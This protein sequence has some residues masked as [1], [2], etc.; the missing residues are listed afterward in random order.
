MQVIKIV[1]V[2]SLLKESHCYWHCGG[3]KIDDD[4]QCKCHSEVLTKWNDYQKR[5]CCGSDTC[6]TD[7][8]GDAICP[9][10]IICNTRKNLQW[11][12]GDIIIAQEKTCQ[13]G[14]L[15][16]PLTYRNYTYFGGFTWCCPSEP[17]SYNQEDGTVIC[18]NATIVKGKDKSCDAGT[19]WSRQYLSCK[20]GKQCVHKKYICHGDPWCLDWSDLGM[21]GPDNEDICPPNTSYY[22][23]PGA[24]IST[25]HQECYDIDKYTNNQQYNCLTRGDETTTEGRSDEMIDYESII[26]CNGRNG[27]GLMCGLECVDIKFWCNPFGAYFTSSCSTNTTTFTTLNP[28]LCQNRTFWQNIGCDSY[29]SDGR[30]LWGAGHRCKGRLQHCYYPYSRYHT[31]RKCSDKSDEVFSVEDV[32]TQNKSKEN[33]EL[34]LNISFNQTDYTEPQCPLSKA[35]LCI[36]PKPVCETEDGDPYYKCLINKTLHCIQTWSVDYCCSSSLFT[37]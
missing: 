12:C 19:I 8:N 31:D 11:V 17:C 33:S 5:Q 2:L 16:P 21:C 22:K 20:S 3:V 15:S 26:P 9:D 1:L 30:L 24:D 36:H 18:Y 32:C 35:H 14:S 6:Y 23:C 29:E 25:D 37:N 13:C 34:C 4:K 27:N 7:S 28:T 10:G